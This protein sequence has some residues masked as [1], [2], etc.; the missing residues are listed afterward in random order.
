MK[1]LL[2]Y[3]VLPKT[4]T[5]FE[6]SYLRKVNRIAL[7]FFAL[8]V[9]AL[10]LLAWAN[11]TKPWLAAVLSVGALAGPALAYATIERPRVI[12]VI[13]GVSAMFFGG[14]LVHFGQGPVQ[15]EMHFYFFALIAML[16]VFGNPLVIV[17]A[18]VT[19][20]LHHLLLW[21][22]VPASVFNYD[23]PVWVVA[24]H[25]AFVVLESVAGIYI[26]RSFFD[27]VIGLEKIVQ[28]RTAELDQ[29]NHDMRLVLDNVEQGFVTV[30]PSGKLSVER[31][32]CFDEWFGAQ[33]TTIF[34]ALTT[35]SPEFSSRFALAWEELAAGVLPAELLIYQLPKR[36]I[37]DETH[38][39]ISCVPIGDDPEKADRYL[40]VVTDVTARVNQERSERESREIFQ[41]FERVLSDRGGVIEYLE[42]GSNLVEGITQHEDS[43]LMTLKRRIHT[44]KGNSAIFGLE[45]VAGLCHNLETG[46]AEEGTAPQR[47]ALVQLQERWGGIADSFDRLIGKRGRIIELDPNEQAALELEA[48]RFSIDLW[49]KIHVLKL[50][51]T[52]RR[53]EN[54][55]EQARRIA[56]RLDKKVDVVI[57]DDS[58]RV[59]PKLWAPF[60]GALIHGV[61]NAVDHGLERADERL[62]AG[63]S[64]NGTLTLSTL[65]KGDR[66]VV[67]IKDDG[68]GIDWEAVQEKAL[69]AGLPTGSREALIEALFHDGLSTAREVTDL[70]GRGVGLGALLETTEKLEGEITVESEPGQGTTLRM[71]FP[72]FAMAPELASPPRR[73]Q[74]PRQIA[75]A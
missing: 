43:D 53:L 15:I 72:L 45:T 67:E 55:A 71:S 36:L 57:S 29:R 12:S 30:D 35:R 60:W 70:S 61:R 32:R 64:E 68:R 23:A 75:T 26:A 14:L 3:L 59:D 73:S 31:S 7:F 8:H 42:E 28:A 38:F 41:L 25:A 17:A 6:E 48:A 44:L 16:A 27:N 52:R 21:F 18:A 58:L 69:A 37:D 74:L 50:E 1:K 49:R 20:A 4:I 19:V 46:I 22:I 10:L 2:D 65:T 13:Y 54:F 9:P 47:P 39:E 62:E 56:A 11:Q 33:S 51:P 5:A 34:Q 40:I 66:F 24:V 63:K